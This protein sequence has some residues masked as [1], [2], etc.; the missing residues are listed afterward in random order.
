MRVLFH[1][2]RGML[3]FWVDPESPYFKEQLCEERELIL[4]CHSEWRSAPATAT[5]VDMG[6]ENVSH[7][8]GGF[9]AWKEVRLPVSERPQ[10]P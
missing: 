10:R 9:G 2:T 3:E 7:I 4:Y 8:D 1:A 5:L 6:R